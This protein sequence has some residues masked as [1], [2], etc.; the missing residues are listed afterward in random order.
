MLERL[1]WLQDDKC[2]VRARFQVKRQARAP[3][4][5]NVQ[6]SGESWR[7]ELKVHGAVVCVLFSGVSQASGIVDAQ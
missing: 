3:P 4:W 7:A 6:V 1:L 2:G 5:T